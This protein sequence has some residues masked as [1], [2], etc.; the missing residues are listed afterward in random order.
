MQIGK[1][2]LLCYCRRWSSV[3]RGIQPIHHS[4]YLSDSESHSYSSSCW[5]S[6]CLSLTLSCSSVSRFYLPFVCLSLPLH[7]FPRSLI[8]M[9]NLPPIPFLNYGTPVACQQQKCLKTPLKIHPDLLTMNNVKAVSW[10]PLCYFA[11]SLRGH[12]GSHKIHWTAG[13]GK[14]S[15][16]GHLWHLLPFLHRLTG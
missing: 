1:V 6:A 14:L 11:E 16:F 12:K 5:F 9:L 10:G 8:A 7:L 3:L 4:N 2:I 13:I 15:L